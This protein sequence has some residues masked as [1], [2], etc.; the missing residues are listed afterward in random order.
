MH[1]NKH[2]LAQTYAHKVNLLKT[3]SELRVH[4]LTHSSCLGMNLCGVRE[5]TSQQLQFEDERSPAQRVPHPC[6]EGLSAYFLSS[7]RDSE[8][9]VSLRALV[10]QDVFLCSLKHQLVPCLQEGNVITLKSLGE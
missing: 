7:A 6:P 10:S 5:C 4:V 3:A 2:T 9:I 8:I 1:R